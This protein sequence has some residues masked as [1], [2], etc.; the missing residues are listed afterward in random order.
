MLLK[1]VSIGTSAVKVI[2]VQEPFVVNNF[3]DS[4]HEPLPSKKNRERFINWSKFWYHLIFRFYT[5]LTKSE[6]WND[7]ARK[8]TFLH[9]RL[10]ENTLNITFEITTQSM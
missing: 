5:Q 10:T 7:Y 6:Q 4:V 2:A 1:M 8:S 3:F 9:I